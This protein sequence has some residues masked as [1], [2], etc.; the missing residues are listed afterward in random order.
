MTELER[1]YR[2]VSDLQGFLCDCNEYSGVCMYVCLH[3]LQLHGFSPTVFKAVS[4]GDTH[5][6][7]AL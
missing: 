3:L 5:V 4:L 1:Q 7:G 6:M 2:I